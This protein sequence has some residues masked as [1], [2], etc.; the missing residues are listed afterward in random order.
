MA[1]LLFGDAAMAERRRRREGLL[2]KATEEE[3]RR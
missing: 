3:Q 2:G 1:K